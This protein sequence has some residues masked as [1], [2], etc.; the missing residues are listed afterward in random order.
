VAGLLVHAPTCK[1]WRLPEDHGQ[2][3]IFDWD[4]IG[5]E[6]RQARYRHDY[7]RGVA[8][9]ARAIIEQRPARLPADYCLHV[10]ELSFAIQNPV[11]TPYQVTTT[12]KPLQPMDDAALKEVISINW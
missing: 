8:E 11:H 2:Q 7:A 9:L 1:Q 10:N 3:F 6:C 12:F 5:R 4:F